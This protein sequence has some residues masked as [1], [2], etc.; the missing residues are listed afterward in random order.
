NS[1]VASL[2]NQPN[3]NNA[4]G[5]FIQSYVTFAKNFINGSSFEDGIAFSSR[6]I[7]NIHRPFYPDGVDG[8]LNGPLSTPYATWSPFNVGLHLH[9]AIDNIAQ[10]LIFLNTGNNALE[11]AQQC[12][13]LPVTAP[14]GTTQQ[15]ANGLQPFAGGFPVYRNGVLVGGLGVSGDGIDQD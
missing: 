8:S 15:L 3:G 13:F 2:V 10:P 7:G 9:L 4:L 5:V 11:T 12:S 1:G 6:G 14:V